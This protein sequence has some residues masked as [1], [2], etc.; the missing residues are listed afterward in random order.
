V[1]EA[2]LG[3]K[4][5]SKALTH[6]DKRVGSGMRSSSVGPVEASIYLQRVLE[7]WRE[8]VRAFRVG[9]TAEASLLDAVDDDAHVRFYDNEMTTARAAK[10]AAAINGKGGGGKGKGRGKHKNGGKGDYHGGYGGGG[11]VGDS[12]NGGGYGGDGGKGGGKG[13]KGDGGKGGKGDGGKGGGGKGAKGYSYRNRLEE[14]KMYA[15]LDD[16]KEK[17]PDYC[18]ARGALPSQPLAA[19]ATRHGSG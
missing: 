8:A 19:P 5:T 14:Q 16:F 13:G 9:T 18:Q 4:S 12:H 6:L 11:Y 7:S 1:Y 3:L 15:A 10:A 2:E 17:F